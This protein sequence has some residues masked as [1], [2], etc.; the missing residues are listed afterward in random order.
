M[1]TTCRRNRGRRGP[2]CCASAATGHAPAIVRIR[3]DRG[4]GGGT[5]RP[6]WV[7][8]G[9]RPRAHQ[10]SARCGPATCRAKRRDGTPAFTSS[11]PFSG[12]RAGCATSGES[13]S[14]SWWP[15]PSGAGQGRRRGD[16]GGIRHAARRC[17]QPRDRRSR[18][19]AGAVWEGCPDN[20][21][22]THAGR[23]Q[24]QRSP[25][26]RSGSPERPHVIPPIFA[27][28]STGS[29]PTP[30]SRAVCIAEYAVREGALHAA[31]HRPGAAT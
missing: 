9:G 8:T 11:Q 26:G 10:S 19:M 2:V 22:F 5:G 12:A 27:W 23:R 1:S 18:R 30:W 21:A 16:R 31:L 3:R 25:K 15:R 20:Q 24:G 13:G 7:L 29:P 28:R 14:P 17:R 6:G 4:A